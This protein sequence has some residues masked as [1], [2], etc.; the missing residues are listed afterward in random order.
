MFSVANFVLLK[1][2][3][4]MKQFVLNIA[5]LKKWFSS[6]YLENAM[7]NAME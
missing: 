3:L 2:Q 4:V 1:K 6:S 5:L 7:K